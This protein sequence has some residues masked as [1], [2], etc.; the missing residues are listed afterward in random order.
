M[1]FYLLKPLLRGLF[2]LQVRIL[3]LPGTELPLTAE[4]P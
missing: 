4:I 2:I 1:L 3:D